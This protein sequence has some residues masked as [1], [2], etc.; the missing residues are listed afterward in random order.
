[1]FKLCLLC[2]RELP[3]PDPGSM[4][5]EI[6]ASLSAGKTWHFHNVEHWS[7]FVSLFRHSQNEFILKGS[8]PFQSLSTLLYTLC[9]FFSVLTALLADQILRSLPFD[10][11][12]SNFVS[13]YLQKIIDLSNFCSLILKPKYVL[14][15]NHILNESFLIFFYN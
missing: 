4:K 12:I 11:L 7:I 5:S 6:C 2:I 15:L 8:V 14:K 13:L 10:F 9:Q 1:M 3:V